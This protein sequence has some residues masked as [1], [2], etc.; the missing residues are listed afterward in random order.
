MAS[1]NNLIYIYGQ[2]AIIEALKKRPDT[3]SEVFLLEKK[4]TL[5]FKNLLKI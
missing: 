3:V 2:N 5:N 1:M 4:K